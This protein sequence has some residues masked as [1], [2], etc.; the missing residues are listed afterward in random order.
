[1]TSPPEPTAAATGRRRLSARLP[2]AAEVPEGWRL[3]PVR[4]AI[5]RVYRFPDF[6][7]AFAFMARV[8]LLAER[9]DHHPEWRNVWNRVEIVLTTHDAGGITDLDLEMGAAI[10]SIARSAGATQEAL[11]IS[12]SAARKPSR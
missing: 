2:G 7:A 1:M 12:P 3:D 9:M 11:E 8:A 10:E 6:G 5:E 4:P